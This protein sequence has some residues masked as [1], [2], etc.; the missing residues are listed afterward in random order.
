MESRS[1]DPSPG[2][3]VTSESTLDLESGHLCAVSVVNRLFDTQCFRLLIPA[4]SQRFHRIIWIP[5]RDGTLSSKVVI[6]RRQE[7]ILATPS[8]STS[9]LRLN[10]NH[11]L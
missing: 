8:L 7:L 10:P 4:P 11:N 9:Q 1:Y 3:A 5:Q 2:I 6:R